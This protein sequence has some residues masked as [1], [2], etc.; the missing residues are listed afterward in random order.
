MDPI[1]HKTSPFPSKPTTVLLAWLLL[2]CPERSS[3]LREASEMDV[4]AVENKIRNTVLAKRI[5][6]SEYFGDYDKLH[7]GYITRSQFLRCL[8]Q[9]IGIRL[10]L[11]ESNALFS[12]YDLKCN[13]I[14]NYK[15]FVDVI[16]KRFSPNEMDK[17]PSL[18]IVKAPE[19][20]Q[21]INPEN[22][23][24]IMKCYETIMKQLSFYY[25]YHGI[26]VLPP[27]KD[28][29]KLNSGTV[30]DNQFRR[31]IIRP[32]GLSDEM[33]S[34][35]ASHY[36]V[37]G[38]PGFINYIYF[39][40]DVCNRIKT[41]EADHPVRPTIPYGYWP[42]ELPKSPEILEVFDKIRN[43][44][45]IK[46]IRTPEFF[47]DY[48]RLHSGLITESQFI[49]GLNLACGKEGNFTEQDIQTLL[50]CFSAPDGKVRY[51]D[52]CDV[53]EHAFNIPHLEKYPRAEVCRPPNGTLFQLGIKLTGAEE[54]R[55][56]TVLGELS[57]Q[58]EKRQLLVNPFFRDYDEKVAYR[59]L[60]SKS[61]FER[62]LDYL[63]LSV[64][65]MDLR[66]L[67]KKFGDPTTGDVNYVAFSQAIDKEFTGFKVDSFE[68]EMPAD[69]PIDISPEEQQIGF[70]PQLKTESD[71][72]ALGA[73]LG[74]LRHHVLVNRV[75][76][77]DFIEDFDPL[78]SGRIPTSVF[79]RALSMI[80]FDPELTDIQFR[81]LVKCYEDPNKPGHIV[82]NNFTNDI[83]SVFTIPELEKKPTVKVPPLETYQLPKVGT[84]DAD[85]LNPPERTQ[86]EALMC[87]LKER[88][89]HRHLITHP[90]FKDFD[91]YNHGH[92]S[93]S[94]F[95]RCLAQLNLGVTEKEV[96]LLEEVFLDELGIDYVRFLDQVDPQPKPEEKYSKL[97]SEIHQLNDSKRIHEQGASND[98]KCILQKIKTKVYRT[99][100][101]IGDHMKDFD[102]LNSGRILKTNFRRALDLDGFELQPSE[103]AILEK[104]YESCK[105]PDFVD[106]KVFINEIESIFTVDHL[107][108]SP[109]AEVSQYKPP[110]DWTLNTL[111][112][113]E[114]CVY[115]ETL[116]RLAEKVRK[117]QIQL[118]PPFEDYDRLNIGSVTQS[119][120]HR[121]LTELDLD[122]VLSLR[123]I[124]ILMQRF[125]VK[126]GTG[127]NV[128]Y[129]A[130]CDAVYDAA[131]MD[132]R[133]P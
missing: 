78:R 93:R 53:M 52:F 79:R 16:D 63:G 25:K 133:M 82:W 46:G 111:S 81:T 62:T 67:C 55:L 4:E 42:P 68:L 113:E 91:K 72:L 26:D 108:K 95:H 128:N 30:T 96:G 112:A 60:L 124:R 125:R 100:A 29:D 123:D 34:M 104:V 120:F 64:L 86:F 39:C 70:K 109:Q 58:V 66:L 35:I 102:K 94:Q 24:D 38:K 98:I 44:V 13:G 110:A 49:R 131:Q 105:E 51:R 27:F 101:K 65:P 18:Q 85:I 84:V 76:T 23:P 73:L 61:Q 74:R 127:D 11:E 106:Y 103:M 32:I 132:K 121:V 1:R 40:N 22:D 122:N 92:L 8:D 21:D 15:H 56:E 50:K 115:E 119:Q 19:I 129:I 47:K 20:L 7:S 33:V 99:R 75:R 130:F 37:P 87:R 116:G 107:E 88:I 43:I 117:K 57:Q 54:K 17:D 5:R 2:P 36:A 41:M 45:F 48:D 31:A 69:K 118:F 77:V 14:I 114:I 10:T 83:D 71:T 9:T 97:M 28:L 59:R 80:G 12:K 6:I 3:P 89:S 126:V 90:V